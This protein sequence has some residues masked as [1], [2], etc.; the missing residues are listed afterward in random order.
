MMANQIR[1]TTLSAAIVFRYIHFWT[2]RHR[3]LPFWAIA[4]YVSLI[5][6][7]ALAVGKRQLSNSIERGS[8][9]Y[10]VRIF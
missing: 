7:K 6:L 10:G 5:W 1:P 2:K 8:S 9:R 4:Q 3:E